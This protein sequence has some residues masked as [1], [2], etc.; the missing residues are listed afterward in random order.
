M[1]PLH[2]FD[3]I[4]STQ[5][6]ALERLRTGAPAGTT[7]IAACQTAGRGR[8]DHTWASPLGGVYLSK[9]ALAPRDGLPLVPMA[10]ALRIA[11]MLET[12]FAVRTR[13]RWPNDLWTVGRPRPGKISGVLADHVVRGAEEL[14]VV[15]VGINATSSR[16]EFPESLRSTVAIL[17][18]IS[19]GPV[20]R[21]S[22]ESG[23]EEAIDL[24][25]DDLRR[26]GGPTRVVAGARARLDGL[27][28]P[29]TIDGQR[30]GRI[31]GLSDGGGL[32]VEGA[33]GPREVLAG[34]VAFEEGPG[35]S[36]PG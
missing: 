30:A 5:A 24:A 19:E 21:G 6:E 27:G 10:V 25:L 32:I 26:P 12:R 34:T 35:A 23:T 31:V 33:G 15:G 3:R 16:S 13:L 9:I 1:R 2:R 36:G 11:E 28:R 8:M 7:V 22:L 14:V 20:D 17:A 29:V 4:A 18:E